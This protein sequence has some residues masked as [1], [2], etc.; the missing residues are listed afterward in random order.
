MTQRFAIVLWSTDVS[1]LARFLCEVTGA[2]A[3]EAYPGFAAL[4]VGGTRIEL[5]DDE[6]YRG[7][8]WY[9]ALRREGA[10]RGIGTELRAEV[11]DVEAAYRRALALGGTSVQPPYPGDGYVEA[12][13]MGPDGYLLSLWAPSPVPGRPP[14]SV[15]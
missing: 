13:V 7:H 5:H 11:E 15:A 2:R 6:A 12:V 9:D 14:G 1:A 10:A 3:L 4:E 8:P